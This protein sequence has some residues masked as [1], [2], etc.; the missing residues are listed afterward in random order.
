MAWCEFARGEQ[1]RRFG[2]HNA[3]IAISTSGKAP[4]MIKMIGQPNPSC[5][6]RETTYPP[7]I[8]VRA[9]VKLIMIIIARSRCGV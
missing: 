8:A 9:P 4:P 5:S 1:T 7:T 6:R 3:A 2:S